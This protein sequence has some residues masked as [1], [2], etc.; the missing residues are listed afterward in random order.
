MQGDMYKQM[1]RGEETKHVLKF[2]FYKKIN[3]RKA[4]GNQKIMW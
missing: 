4:R 3:A 2:D 1:L